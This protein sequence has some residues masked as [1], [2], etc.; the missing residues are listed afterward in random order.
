[1]EPYKS[2]DVTNPKGVYGASKLAGEELVTVTCDKYIILR[3]AWVF[4]EYGN[5]F[6]K[7]MLRLGKE[8]DSLGVFADQYGSP[9]YAGDIV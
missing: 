3:T 7:T 5:N 1:M 9:T 4:S 8:R 6:V 2:S